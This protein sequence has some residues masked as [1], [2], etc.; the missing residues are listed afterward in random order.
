[1][2]SDRPS[3]WPFLA[4]GGE[5]GAL[6]ASHDWSGTSIGPIGTWPQSLRT[7][8]GFLLRSPVPLVMLWGE[9]GVMLYNDAYS[10]FAGGRHPALLGSKVREG[11]PEVADFN[12]H[13]MKVGL[14]GGTLA[15]KDQELTLY[16]H[17]RPEQVFMNLDYSPVPGDDG[18]PAG[19]LAIVVETTERVAA[20]RQM[21]EGEAR[22]RGVFNSRLKGLTIFDTI[23]SRTVEIND[24]F[25]AMTGHSRADFDEG[26]W[27]WRDF[28]LPEYL[29]L[30]EAAIAQARE[31]GTWEPYEK[32]YRRLD[33]SRF[34]VRL[35]C[36]PLP[37]E[38]GRV[39]VSV[40]DISAERAQEA[41]LRESQQRFLLAQQAAGIGVWDW[42]LITD[43]IAWSPEIYTLSGIDPETPADRLF[44]A[45]TEALHPEDRDFAIGTA[46][47]AAETG[48]GFSF[49]F[50][51]LLPDGET[52]WLRSQ[53]TAVVESG[54]PVRL[55]GINVD[56]TAQHRIEEA[57]RDQA[58]K[59]EAQVAL[60][61]AERDQL[62]SLSQDMLA[63]ADYT[64]MMSA[65]SPAWRRILGWSESEL[66]TRPYASFM[67][68]DDMP[69]TLAAIG[70]M[71]ETGEPT[72][73]ENRILAS[74]GGYKPIEWTVAPEP[75][76]LN[77]IAVGRDLSINKARES[78]LAAAQEALRQSQKMEA[79]GQL[80]GGVAHDFNNLLTP[81]VGALDMLQRKGVGGEREQRLVGGALQSAERAKILVQRLLAFARR[82]PL[83]ATAVDIARLVAGMADLIR[84]TSGPQIKV[85][86]EAP[87]GLPAAAA[88]ANQLEMALLNLA[89]NARDAMPDGGTL[90]ITAN[91]EG[92]GPGHPSKLA[93]GR[94]MRLSVADTGVGMDEATLARAIEP[95]FSTKGIG[96]GT[97]L[98]L[99]MVHGLASQLGGALT[100]QS[101]HGLGT[102]VELWLPISAASAEAGSETAERAPKAATAGAALLVDDEEIVRMSTASML[103]DL[104]YAVVEAGSAEEALRLAR[105]GL[106]PD[107]LVTDHLMPGMNGT[108]LARAMRLERPDLPVLIVSGYAE[109]EGIAPDLPRLAKPFRNEELAASLAALNRPA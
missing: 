77:F 58:E 1:L 31:R 60:R 17:G 65:V 84:S 102:N 64:G 44:E 92:I 48:E 91:E 80:T 15:Y 90:S 6:I 9:D 95:F 96:K 4:S 56:V 97:G 13:V 20:E 87:A 35:T 36:A 28:T 5:A 76:G 98:G 51:I 26:R 59:L 99:S 62:W 109:S 8:L 41:D 18:R 86:M 105:E 78:E 108:D 33:G 67:H 69:P 73:F 46:R 72:R 32:E 57:L 50:R 21:R 75:D 101:R 53:A 30:D 70:R 19:V 52:R 16:R 2:A 7:M 24:T 29:H 79:M 14:A 100:I 12:D 47:R 89:V 81:I 107:L 68:P 94:Y 49:D 66:L 83:Q 88:D 74:D 38:P 106:R 82:Q 3:D 55:A 37:N 42:N 34:P 25:L 39:V 104:G 63:R 103:A 27:D 10:V 11:W 40:Q 93:P 85:V 45:W 23:S 54:R 71:A 61:S 22:F 43:A